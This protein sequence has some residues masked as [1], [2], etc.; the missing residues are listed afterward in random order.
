[1][2]AYRGFGAFRFNMEATA[3][4]NTGRA[5]QGRRTRWT[6]RPAFWRPRQATRKKRMPAGTR[7]HRCG[8]TAAKRRSLSSS[9]L[10]PTECP[11]EKA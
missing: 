8:F 2:Y 7:Y 1:M 3:I 11:R 10:G 4:K 5:T 6:D 9:V